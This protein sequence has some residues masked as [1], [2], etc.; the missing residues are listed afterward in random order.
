MNASAAQTFRDATARHA[1]DYAPWLDRDPSRAALAAAPL[2][3]PR[4]EAWRHTNPNRWYG[5]APSTPRRQLDARASGDVRII[6]FEKAD[7]GERRLI[8]RHLNATLDRAHHPLANV[9]DILLDR[10]V[11]LRIP[12]A[13]APAEVTLGDMGGGYERALVL[14][15]AG[16][17]CV[18][19][20]R[21]AAPRQRVVEVVLAPDASLRHLR[22]QPPSEAAEH[23]L[24]SVQADAGATYALTQCGGGA[25]LR[26]SDVHIEATGAGADITV[27]SAYR[28]ARGQHLDTQ[29]AVC[30]AAPAV[31][32]RQFVRGAVGAAARA[33]FDG[34]IHIA[35]AGQ[36]A[37]A[38]LT[39]K[40]LLLAPDAAAYA[41]PELTIYANDVKCAHG[42]TM[43]EL[44][45]NALFYLHSRGVGDEQARRLLVAGFLKEALAETTDAAAL[46]V[47]GMAP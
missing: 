24:V 11:L 19:T 31:T 39:A 18:L 7:A 9:N 5:A 13:A 37:A 33:V 6:P 16:A 44:D 14:V 2:P 41:K 47:L 1:A 35:P 20:E 29:L 42:A 27:R 12:R 40:H 46:A 23:H 3:E 38:T 4:S 22:L 17:A 21:P 32:S 36:Q 8:A 30:H 43:G 26:R 28:L 34:R 10:G 45:D 25:P 15:E